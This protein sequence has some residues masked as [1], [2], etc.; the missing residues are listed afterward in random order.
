MVA[1]FLL[2]LGTRRATPWLMGLLACAAFL[3][4]LVMWRFERYM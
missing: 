4:A 1:S 2:G 3:A